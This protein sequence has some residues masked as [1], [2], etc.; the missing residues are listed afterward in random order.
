[1]C[2]LVVALLLLL[3]VECATAARLG[4]MRFEPRN[5]GRRV[6]VRPIDV[7][8]VLDMYSCVNSATNGGK[9]R[10]ELKVVLGDVIGCF[11]VLR[12]ERLRVRAMD[13]ES[14]GLGDVAS[15]V[16]DMLDFVLVLSSLGFVFVCMLHCTII[17]CS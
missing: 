15:R 12:L 8:S 7:N 6:L 11:G 14:W 13:P 10:D 3:D 2:R 16:L 4:N 5:K 1:L 9:P 17:G